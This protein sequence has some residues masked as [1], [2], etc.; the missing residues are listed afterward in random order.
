MIISPFVLPVRELK[1]DFTLANVHS[2]GLQI[3][4]FLIETAAAL[5]IEAPAMPIAGENA[6]PDCTA[7]QGIAHVG[8]LI[9]AG[10]NPAIDVEQCDAAPFADPDSFR[11]TGWNIA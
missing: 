2:E 3:I 8:A 5:Q 9:V 7:G 4:A 11:L 6:V 1:P 10:I